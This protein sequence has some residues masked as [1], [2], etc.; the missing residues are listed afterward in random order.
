MI[1]ESFRR[2]I[3]G[4]SA[5]DS[6]PSAFTCFR[7]MGGLPGADIDLGREPLARGGLRHCDK[8]K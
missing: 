5:E 6:A 3:G 4:L 2:Q 7:L 1:A 8:G